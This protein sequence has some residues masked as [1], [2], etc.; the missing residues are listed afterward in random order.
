MMDIYIY[1]NTNYDVRARSSAG[2]LFSA[3]AEST[4][5][6]GGAVYG[7]AFDADWRICHAHIDSIADLDSLRRSKYA[8]TDITTCFGQLADDLA[9]GRPLLVVGTPCQIAIIRKK[10]GERANMLMVEVVCHGAP[11][12]KYWDMYLDEL[13]KSQGKNRADIASINF[14]DKTEGWKNYSVRVDFKDGS[15][16]IQN[17]RDNLYILAFVYDYTLRQGCSKCPYKY[18][19]SKADI[20]MGDFWG[21]YVLAPEANN[22]LGTTIAIANTDKGTTVLSSL[23]D[24]TNLTVEEVAK[25]NPALIKAPNVPSDKP[26][27]EAA[28]AN[29][30]FHS[31]ASRFL[32]S[33]FDRRA[34]ST[35][36]R[37]S[38]KHIIWC[39]YTYLTPKW[40][41]RKI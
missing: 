34:K 11:Q 19:N 18:P 14:R 39:A 10:F 8:F 1:N 6:R 38:A 29:E 4:I 30:G 23:A 13:L 36:L 3:L 25:Y 27:F 33:V 24:A 37:S 41:K 9:S 12:P 5:S 7:A 21:I 28:V 2:G 15:Q 20:S 32:K 31:A 35:S 22:D 17:H 26:E 16:F 40:L